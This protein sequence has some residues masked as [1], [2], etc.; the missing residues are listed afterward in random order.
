MTSGWSYSTGWASTTSTWLTVPARG[1]TIGFITFIASM[2]SRVSPSFT[3]WPGATNGLAPGSPA[4]KTVPTIGDL[5]T[6]GW[7]AGDA[8]AAAGAAAGAGGAAAAGAGAGA[9]ATATTL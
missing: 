1:A 2:I 5:T 9:A 3:G 6:P 8:A 4:R 7:L